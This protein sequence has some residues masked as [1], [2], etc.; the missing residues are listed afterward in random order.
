VARAFF[1]GREPGK[2]DVPLFPRFF[3]CLACVPLTSF[4]QTASSSAEIDIIPGS[5][6]FRLCHKTALVAC[7]EN[8]LPFEVFLPGKTNAMGS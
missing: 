8:Q 7:V 6:S 1:L 5:K 2:F 3:A 4:S